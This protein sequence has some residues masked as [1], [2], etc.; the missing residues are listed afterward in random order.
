MTAG[1]AAVYGDSAYGAGE[2]LAASATT[3]GIDAKTKVQPP[4][5]PAG[6]F[7]KDQFDIDLQAADCHLPER[8]HH[9]DPAGHG[10]DRHAG[11]ADFGK[12]CPPARCASSAPPRSPGGS[13]TIS[14]HE[15]R[16]AAARTRQRD[17]AWKAD[18]RATRPKVER[19][20]AHLMRRRHGGRRARM[21]G[22]YASPPTSPSSPPPST[23]PDSPPSASPTPTEAGPS[24]PPEPTT[25]P[26]PPP[27]R[28]QPRT[29]PPQPR[30][31]NNL[32]RYRPQRPAPQD[33]KRWPGPPGQTTV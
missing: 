2:V 22:P 4:V 25:G 13:I 29:Q 28:P 26:R 30:P 14:R 5:A 15:A 7:T 17:P 27:H 3:P 8:H 16:L 6:K 18:Y 31:S 12:A 9:P 21:R 10:H 32:T 1:D 19:K 11:K 20:L 33:S 24:T 23:S